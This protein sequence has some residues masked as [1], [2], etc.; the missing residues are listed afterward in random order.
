MKMKWSFN[1]EG[2]KHCNTF[3]SFSK[4]LILMPTITAQK[5]GQQ[6][7]EVF[8]EFSTFEARHKAEKESL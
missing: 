3:T 5:V 6:H 4:D 8:G 1:W 2:V 7:T